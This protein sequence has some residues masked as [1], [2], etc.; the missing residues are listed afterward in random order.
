MSAVSGVVQVGDLS[1]VLPDLCIL[2]FFYFYYILMLIVFIVTSGDLRRPSGCC[3]FRLS[4]FH[5]RWKQS[6]ADHPSE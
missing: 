1:P 5:G 4:S 3:F 6:G 2:L